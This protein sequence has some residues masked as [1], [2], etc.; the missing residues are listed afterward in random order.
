MPVHQIHEWPA[1]IALQFQG[2][3]LHYRAVSQLYA[4]VGH[5]AA[6]LSVELVAYRRRGCACWLWSRLLDNLAARCA[7]VMPRE[8][9]NMQDCG[10]PVHGHA[11]RALNL[12]PVK[13]FSAAGGLRQTFQVMQNDVIVSQNL[14]EMPIGLPVISEHVSVA[15]CGD[16]QR[17]GHHF[18][19]S[20]SQYRLFS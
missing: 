18:V 10:N 12:S 19:T 4:V 17:R 3:N 2:M 15:V 13:N 9:I 14:P 11:N 6:I 1:E 5:V 16:S 7:R 8:D 20:N